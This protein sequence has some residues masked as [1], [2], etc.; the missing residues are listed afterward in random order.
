[1]NEH[2]KTRFTKRIISCLFNNLTRKKISVLGFA[3]K[4]DTSDTRESPAIALVTNF[5]AERAQVAIYDPKVKES[6]IWKELVDAGGK[7]GYLKQDILIYKSAYEACQGADAV[8]IVT[9]RD[10]FNNKEL[11]NAQKLETNQPQGNCDHD[12]TTGRSTPVPV[13]LKGTNQPLSETSPHTLNENNPSLPTWELKSTNTPL[14]AISQNLPQSPSRTNR[15]KQQP[16]SPPVSPVK[17]PSS[18]KR[19]SRYLFYVD[20]PTKERPSANNFG[21]EA[22][23]PERLDRARVTKGMRKP[24]WVFDGRNIL[25]GAKLEV[26]GFRY[27]AIGKASKYAGFN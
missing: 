6:Q 5:V 15:T 13:E 10:E 21:P 24:M 2:Q 3:F 20:Q 27:E 25:D 12:K 26:L 18:A 8:V 11:V 17:M 23:K 4:K 1:M 19:Y 9:E 16:E 22:A 14:K 7:A